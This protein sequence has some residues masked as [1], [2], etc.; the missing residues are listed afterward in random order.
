MQAVPLLAVAAIAIAA[1]A[2]AALPAAAANAQPAPESA[3]QATGNIAA[4]LGL[5]LGKTRC[6]RITQGPNHVR[7]GKAAWAGGDAIEIRNLERFNLPGLARVIVNC[8]AQDTVAL[9]TL[10]FERPAFDD[11]RGKLDKRYDARRKTEANAE[12]GYA[13]WLANNGSIEMLHAREGR[14]FT[15]AYWGKGAKAR[16]FAYNGGGAS[17]PASAAGKAPPPAVKQPAAL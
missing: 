15:V 13:E 4:P 7:A 1:T 17:A 9:V 3:A 12:N 6:A 8:D 14:Q 2:A 11:V 16:Y 10:T 5:E